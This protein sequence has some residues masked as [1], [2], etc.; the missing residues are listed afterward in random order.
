MDFDDNDSDTHFSFHDLQS[1]T[2][3]DTDPETAEDNHVEEEK[4]L[5]FHSCLSQLFK[6]CINCR[7]IVSDVKYSVT[8][9]LVSVTTTCMKG[10]D[11]TWD[12]QPILNNHS[13]VGN[14]LLSSS[15]L[16][17]GSKFNAM[18]NFAI[19]LNL[20]FLSERFIIPHSRTLLVSSHQ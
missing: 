10:H 7:E 2:Q 16:F 13:R 15:I 6:Y 17:T 11:I 3:T 18:K 20:K 1:S 8:G 9:S 19:S 4:Y 14:L 12:S 5:V